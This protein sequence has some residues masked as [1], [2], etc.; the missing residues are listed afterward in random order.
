MRDRAPG[1]FCTFDRIDP[2]TH[3]NVLIEAYESGL[4]E[5]LTAEDYKHIIKYIHTEHL[6]KPAECLNEKYYFL[7]FRTGL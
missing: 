3:F 2:L 1:K 6:G 5:R 7:G 4:S